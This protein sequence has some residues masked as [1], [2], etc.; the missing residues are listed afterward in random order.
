MI[1]STPRVSMP[2]VC[3]SFT[4]SLVSLSAIINCSVN[5][6][7]LLSSAVIMAIQGPYLR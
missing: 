5:T 4:S 3:M 1:T 6:L 7:A 2:P